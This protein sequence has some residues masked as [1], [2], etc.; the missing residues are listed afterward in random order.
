LRGQ[1]LKLLTQRPFRTLQE[2]LCPIKI[3]SR[4]L[5]RRGRSTRL[6][7]GN[8]DP[9]SGKPKRDVNE[10]ARSASLW[11][12]LPKS[13]HS[14][15]CRIF[16]GQKWKRFQ[17]DVPFSICSANS[18]K[19]NP[20][21]DQTNRLLAPDAKGVSVSNRSSTLENRASSVANTQ[22]FRKKIL[23]HHVNP[24]T[25]PTF[26]VDFRAGRQRI[27]GSARAIKISPILLKPVKYVSRGPYEFRVPAFVET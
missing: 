22:G 16:F 20:G 13:R 21:R 14:S 6:E 4:M 17:P 25:R 24:E 8:E 1:K 15:T 5:R 7:R 2:Q 9:R 3:G 12:Q 27:G 11:S 10:S 19:N 26:H 23:G 18:Q